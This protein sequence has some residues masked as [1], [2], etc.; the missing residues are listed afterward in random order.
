MFHTEALSAAGPGSTKPPMANA[1]GQSWNSS[2]AVAVGSVIGQELRAL[3][4]DTGYY[5]IQPVTKPSFGR[6]E[7]TSSEDPRLAG[8]MAV[9]FSAGM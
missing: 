9:G 1:I 4:T 6:I 7:E 8:E 3:G 5:V 2:V